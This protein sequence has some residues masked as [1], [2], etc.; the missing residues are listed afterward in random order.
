MIDY[1]ACD[2]VE[3]TSELVI[4]RSPGGNG[5]LPIRSN[6]RYSWHEVS[7]R[8]IPRS[9]ILRKGSQITC[10]GEVFGLYILRSRVRISLDLWFPATASHALYVTWLS[11]ARYAYHIAI[12]AH[13][14]YQTFM[15]Y[16][17]GID[18]KTPI[19]EKQQRQ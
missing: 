11:Y 12:N 15:T 18:R 5:V 3:Y 14:M 16:H 4:V 13:C 9:L 7:C 2:C 1:R 10:V 8:P 17:R 19:D 6:V